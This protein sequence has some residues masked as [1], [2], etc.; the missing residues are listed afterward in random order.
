MQRCP[1][2]VFHCSWGQQHEA[3]AIEAY[4]TTLGPGVSIQDVGVLSAIVGSLE[5]L[6]MQL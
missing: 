6:R 5:H 2:R 4:R 3:D 1:V